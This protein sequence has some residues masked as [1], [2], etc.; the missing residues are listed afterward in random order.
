MMA[1]PR[2][3]FAPRFRAVVHILI[4]LFVGL[5]VGYRCAMPA[6][7]ANFIIVPLAL[8]LGGIASAYIELANPGAAPAHGQTNPYCFGR[9]VGQ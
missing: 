2:T 9:E 6:D 7:P 4:A 1:E 5:I 8:L 3:Q